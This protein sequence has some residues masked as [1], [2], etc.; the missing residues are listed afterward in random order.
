MNCD[1]INKWVITILVVAIIIDVMILIIE[2]QKQYNAD[3]SKKDQEE[4]Y[5]KLES[6][7]QNLCNE[8]STL[9]DNYRRCNNCPYFQQ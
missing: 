1:N 4:Q 5:G 7:L 6:Q 8:L 3:C 2:F 9:R